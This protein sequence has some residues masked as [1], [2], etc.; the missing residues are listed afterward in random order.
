[1]T[2]NKL[3][4]T[5][6]KAALNGQISGAG[7]FGATNQLN[8]MAFDDHLRAHNQAMRDHQHHMDM[9][10]NAVQHFNDFHMMGPHF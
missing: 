1:M 2:L 5:V 9:H 3:F 7:S 10:M 4:K 6:L 8:N